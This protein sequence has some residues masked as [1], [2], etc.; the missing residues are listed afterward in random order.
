MQP[1]PFVATILLATVIGWA[2]LVLCYTYVVRRGFDFTVHTTTPSS[3][4]DLRAYR[5]ATEHGLE[6]Q[7]TLLRRLRMV[8]PI[9][10]AVLVASVVLFILAGTKGQVS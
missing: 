8:W 7:R 2:G 1:L 3:G 5:S 10:A 6:R 4:H 9:M